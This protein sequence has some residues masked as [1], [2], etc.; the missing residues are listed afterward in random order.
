M[1]TNN[2][3]TGTSIIFLGTGAADWPEHIQDGDRQYPGRDRRRFCSILINRHILVDCG[4]TVPEALDIFES[5]DLDITDILLTHS[6]SDHFSVDALNNIV[7]SNSKTGKINLWGHKTAISE[8]SGVDGVCLNP[9]KPGEGFSISGIHIE[10]LSANHVVS[11]S[12]EKP[13]HYLFSSKGKQWLYATDGAWLLN[14]TVKSLQKT[15]LD[16]IIWDATIGDVEG[17]Y[18]VFEHNSLAMIYLMAS[19]LKNQGILLPDARIILTHMARTLHT[20]HEELERVLA[21]KGMI[22]AYDGMRIEL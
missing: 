9:V 7:R 16:A 13:L 10:A 22:P 11:G 17:D 6:H 8:A 19:S 18:R 20:G 3:N 2:D 4:P 14:P 21:V 15:K 12:R 5:E 1:K